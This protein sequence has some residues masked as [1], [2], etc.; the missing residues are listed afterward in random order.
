M[1]ENFAD[2]FAQKLNFSTYTSENAPAVQSPSSSTED[3]NQDTKTVYS[4]SQH[5]HHSAHLAPKASDIPLSGTPLYSVSPERS[6]SIY[7]LAENGVTPA[8]LLRSQI[9]LFEQ[10]SD[11]QRSRL[12]DLWRLAPPNYTSNGGQELADNIGE[13]QVMTLEQEEEL[14]LVRHQKNMQIKADPGNDSAM[15]Q[16]SGYH[17]PFFGEV[18]QDYSVVTPRPN[19]LLQNSSTQI[20]PL[21]D[22]T[23]LET[24]AHPTSTGLTIPAND[25][26]HGAYEL[27]QQDSI[28]Y[29]G[30]QLGQQYVEHQYGM[31]DQMNR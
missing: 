26:C 27:E 12:L 4:I 19:A 22:Q 24:V 28:E 29:P 30:W 8:S 21:D 14:A 5:Y 17:S 9:T 13:Y 10:S 11:E 23:A 20:S 1:P 15:D 3:G 7:I 2:M 6:S 31:F 16:V 18:W 25:Y